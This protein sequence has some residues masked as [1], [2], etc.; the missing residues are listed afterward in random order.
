MGKH[1]KT[2]MILQK[3]R[4]I[5]ER[6]RAGNVFV[7][8]LRQIFYRLVALLIIPNTQ[9]AYASVLGH[10]RNA[11]IDGDLPRDFII[12]RTRR[13]EIIDDT[14]YTAEEYFVGMKELFL[15]RLKKY[16]LPIWANQPIFPVVV[17][18]KDAMLSVLE[19]I[20]DEFGVSPP[21][22][23]RGYN[24]FSQII[25]IY[26][27]LPEGREIHFLMFS[28]F[29]PSGVNIMESF[30]KRMREEGLRNCKFHRLALTKEQ[31]ERYNLPLMMIKPLDTRS[32]GFERKY[33]SNCVELD[34]LD[35]IILRE[36]I[37]DFYMNNF[38][39]TIRNE[40]VKGFTKEKMISQ[41]V[42]KTTEEVLDVIQEDMRKGREKWGMKNMKK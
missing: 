16:D 18:E 4:E 24:S 2:K 32:A 27:E 34:A 15:S 22:S 21:I 12:D 19:P 9:S 20:C 1:E 28:D 17:V 3:I 5:D 36:L 38:D 42:N 26:R 40:N 35:P 7:K 33:G 30:E 41:V 8:T 23:T 39:L 31:V 10:I 6:L 37:E 14:F 11:R 25:K 13:V 29:D